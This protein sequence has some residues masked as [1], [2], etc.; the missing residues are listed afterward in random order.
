MYLTV[1]K[2]QKSEFKPVPAGT[3]LGR[4]YRIIDLGT[5]QGEWQGKITN[6]HKVIFYFELFGEDETGAPLTKDDGKPLIITK[7][8]NF[9]LDERS[10]F[11]KHLQS[12]LKINFETF[13]PDE[14]F[15]LKDILGK[16]AM[17]S[18][19]Q[20]KGK[21][22]EIRSGLDSLM[23]VPQM[24]MKGGLP[25]G[26][27]ELF[28]FDLEKFDSDKFNSLSEAIRNMISSSPE[29]RKAAQGNAPQ[30]QTNDGFDDDLSD[31]PF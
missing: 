11:R 9:S 29:Y 31:V 7:Y 3:H 18:V 5:Q 6:Q 26:V 8:Y 1:S 21:N 15:Y 25:E 19:S 27:N 16:Y 10:T 23:A 17:I 22:N 13:S 24:I 20:Y 30:K 28:M 2:T 14:K 4:L 12:W